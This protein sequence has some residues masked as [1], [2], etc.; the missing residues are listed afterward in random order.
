MRH[1]PTIVAVISGGSYRKIRGM[2]K[3]ITIENPVKTLG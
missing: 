2:E 3:M 1:R